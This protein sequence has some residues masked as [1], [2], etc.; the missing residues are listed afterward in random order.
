MFL[1][2]RLSGHAD[3]DALIRVDGIQGEYDAQAVLGILEDREKELSIE[4]MSYPEVDSRFVPF[5]DSNYAG[6]ITDSAYWT[7]LVVENETDKLQEL[8]LDISKPHLNKVTLYKHDTRGLVSEVRTGRDYPFSQREVR[9]RNFVFKIRLMPESRETYYIRV[10]T[11]SYLQLPVKLYSSRAFVEREYNA[12]LSLGIYYGIMLAMFLYNLVLLL[13][14]RDRVYLHYILY[15]LCFSMLQLVWDG[16]AFQYLWPDSPGWDV[17]SNPFLIVLTSYFVLK[18]SRS[19]LHVAEN[20]KLADRIIG[21]VLT[22]L[23]LNGILTLFIPPAW[24]LRLAVYSATLALALCMASI[25]LVGFGSRPVY[26]YIIAWAA[27][28]VGVILNLLSAYGLL[29]INLITLYSPRVGSAVE[30]V[31]LSLA[32]VNRFNRIKQEKLHEEKQKLLLKSLHEITKTLTSTHDLEVLLKYILKSLSEVTKYENGI[33]ILKQDQRFQVKDFL[34]YAEADLKNRLLEGLEQDESF[35]T[36]I[37]INKAVTLT[38]VDMNSYGINRRAKTFTGIPITYHKQLLGLIVLYSMN[39]KEKN[40]LESQIIYDFAGQIGITIQNLMLFERVKKMATIDG[41]TG[42]FNRIHFTG[43]VELALQELEKESSP[44]SLLMI[45]IDD[46]KHINDNYGHIAGDK[47][48]K[49]LVACM[50]EVLG[51]DSIIGRYGG[52]EFMVLLKNKNVMEAG[53]IAEELRRAVE[54]MCIHLDE[55]SIVQ[56]TIS[57]GVSD[58]SRETGNIWSL[59]EKADQALYVSKQKGKNLVSMC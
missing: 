30:V 10:E 39:K 20:S 54:D 41:L 37:E 15:I 17:R 3:G 4:D 57:V 40:D 28:F 46:F 23:A 16:L 9:H 55:R 32:L 12:Q 24:A 53:Q 11:E 50:K 31:L 36:I 49:E 35:K 38:D 2:F 13:A 26:L 1:I 48:L 42:A 19:F 29:P 34:G 27:M 47:V 56:F 22:I 6:K 21:I 8:F 58:T 52:E 51:P 14:L 25:W 5:K 45:D 18:F 33:I 59:L 7:K 43:I 44:M